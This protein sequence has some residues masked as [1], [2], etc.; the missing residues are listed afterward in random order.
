[1]CSIMYSSSKT[2]SKKEFMDGFD[3]IKYRVPDM[4][5]FIDDE[6]GM[7]GFHRLAIMDLSEHG[8]QPFELDGSRLICN[9]EIYRYRILKKELERDY[10]FI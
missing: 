10:Q 3:K 1:M 6:T 9:G 8:M 7:W 5:K 4:I 2:I